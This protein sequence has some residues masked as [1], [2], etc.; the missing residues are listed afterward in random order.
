MSESSGLFFCLLAGTMIKPEMQVF[1]ATPASSFVQ[2]GQ[3]EYVIDNRFVTDTYDCSE[4]H[5]SH[6]E[7]FQHGHVRADS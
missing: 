2:P 6:K 4:Q 3:I 5:K 1:S 7:I